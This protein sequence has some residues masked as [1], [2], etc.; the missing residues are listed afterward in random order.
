MKRIEL[1]LLIAVAVVSTWHVVVRFTGADHWLIALVQ[2]ATLS[3]MLAFFAHSVASRN[4]WARIVAAAAL[5]LFAAFSA[6]FQT[7]HFLAHDTG[8]VESVARGCWAPVAEVT[9]GI[10]LV[11]ETQTQ[12]ERKTQ[13]KPGR[14]SA[15]LEAAVDNATQRIAQ[16]Q[17]QPATQPVSAEIPQMEAQPEPQPEAQAQAE[18]SAEPSDR[19]AQIVAAL[20][21]GIKTTGELCAIIEVSPN[22]LRKDLRSMNGQIMPAGRGKW[23]LAE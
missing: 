7:M 3:A 19:E 16:P 21:D 15:L 8:I 14:F 9:L 12:P 10:L 4:G 5:L 18:K 1:P 2:G 13:R 22:T 17:A 23:G 11:R 6:T 20:R